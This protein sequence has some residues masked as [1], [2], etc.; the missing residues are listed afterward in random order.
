MKEKD[1]IKQMIEKHKRGY[2]T[3]MQY[4]ELADLVEFVYLGGD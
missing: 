3:L 2:L 4:R 1:K